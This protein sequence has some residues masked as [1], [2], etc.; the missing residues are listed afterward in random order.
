MIDCFLMI[1]ETT[2]ALLA[3][4]QN[5]KILQEKGMDNMDIVVLGHICKLLQ[6][7][8]HTQELLSSEKTPMFL[9]VVPAYEL[10]FQILRG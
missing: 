4:P 10:I 8:H 9:L 3:K 6:V 7:F 5:H 1:Q 2:T